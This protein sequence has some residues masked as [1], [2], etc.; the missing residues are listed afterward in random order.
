[1]L[2]TIETSQTQLD[3]LLAQGSLP[4]AQALRHALQF[5]QALRASNE[6]GHPW[7]ACQDSFGHSDR[8]SGAE[9]V[10]PYTPPEVLA[11]S[12][13]DVRSDVYTLGAILYHLLTGRPPFSD[14]YPAAGQGATAPLGPPACLVPGLETVVFRCLD[15]DPNQRFQNLQIVTIELKLLCAAADR[16]RPVSEGRHSAEFGLREQ[17]DRL[18]A[19]LAARDAISEQTLASLREAMSE[20]RDY[21]RT[22]FEFAEDRLRSQAVVIDKLQIAA[23]R[24]EEGLDHLTTSVALCEQSIAELRR[25]SEQS[26]AEARSAMQQIDDRFETQARSIHDLHATAGRTDDLLE[27]VVE[28][29]DSLLSFILERTGEHSLD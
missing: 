2:N 25:R 5:V 14:A 29:I 24:S 9:A 17:V 11:G 18:E 13:A 12:A 19:S 8:E 7:S 28:S 3:I 21:V 16:L 10:R 15:K 1:M 20:T 27:R 23:R 22:A 6:G 4:P 26:A